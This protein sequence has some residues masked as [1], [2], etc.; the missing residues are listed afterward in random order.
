MKRVLFSL[1]IS[2]VLVFAYGASV[3]IVWA[4]FFFEDETFIERFITPI[5]VPFAIADSLFPDRGED[6]DVLGAVLGFGGNAIIY[7][8]PIYAFLNLLHSFRKPKKDPFTAEP[9]P[10]PTFDS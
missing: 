4:F 2:V 5:N 7:G 6:G 10:P 8:I 9:P 1:L 3:S